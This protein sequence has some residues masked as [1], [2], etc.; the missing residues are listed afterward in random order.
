MDTNHNI[1]NLVKTTVV[2]ENLATKDLGDI[3]LHFLA[4]KPAKYF[5]FIAC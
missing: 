5:D 1:Q 4:H 2:V 3:S